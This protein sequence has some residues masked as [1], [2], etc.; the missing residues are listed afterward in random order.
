[1]KIAIIG[2]GSTYTPELIEGFIEYREKMPFQEISLMDRDPSRLKIIG[3]FAGRM[4]RRAGMENLL[5]VTTDL[6]EALSDAA[7][8]LTQIR[9]GGSRGRLMDEKIARE[10]GLVAQETTG[11]GGF[12]HA[13]RAIPQM[14]EIARVAECFCPKAWVINFTNPSGIITE[15]L[16]NYSSVKVIGLCNVPLVMRRDIAA[17]LGVQAENLKV[18]S[19]GLNHLSWVRRVLM[20]ETD[21]TA[22]V[23]DEIENIEILKKMDARLVRRLSLIPSPYLRYYY[24]TDSVLKEQETETPRAQKVMDIEQSLLRL[25]AEPGLDIKPPLL[26]ERGGALYSVAALGLMVSLLGKDPVVHTVNIQN[27]G[28]IADIRRS[29]V[30]EIPAEISSRG[31]ES[32]FFGALPPGVAPLVRSVKNY[33]D[34]TIQAAVEGSAV[35]AAEALTAHPLVAREETAWSLLARIIEV[36]GD[37]LPPAFNKGLGKT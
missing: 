22:A 14:L 31:A 16:A 9:V 13:L 11:A 17:A 1:V 21:L 28:A 26:S 33:E 27:R 5:R 7:F 37:L 2:A 35:L 29:S 18:D 36:H 4:L 10:F 20:G 8:V 19:F 24:Q 12:S 3:D 30:V 6:E 25:Y 15:A 32:I 34:L 23:L